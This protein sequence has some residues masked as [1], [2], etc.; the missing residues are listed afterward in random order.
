MQYLPVP[1]WISDGM[2]HSNLLIRNQDTYDSNFF[3]IFYVFQ[4]SLRIS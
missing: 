1:F 3:Y 4:K 2:L